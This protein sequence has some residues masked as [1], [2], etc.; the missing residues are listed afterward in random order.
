MASPDTATFA[1]EILQRSCQSFGG[2]AAAALLESRPDTARRFGPDAFAGWKSD[3]AQRVLEL[4]A[5]LRMGE[6]RIFV[7]RV[8]WA[9]K[10]FQA[11]DHDT[12]DLRASLT[13]LR[14]VLKEQL[15]EQGR[16]AALDYLDQ[17]L[18]ALAANTLPTPDKELDPARPNDRI[19][20]SYLQKI[21][22]GDVAGAVDELC[23]AVSRG[24]PVAE[25]YLEV[26]I[27]AQREIG[28]LWH[29]AQVS[30]AEE[31]LVTGAIQ[32]TMAVLAHDTPAAASNGKTVVVAAVT[33]NAH[34]IGL[35][36]AADLY[37]LAGWRAIFLGADVP[38]EDL[39]AILGIFDADVLLLGVSLAPQLPMASQAIKL[40][41]KQCERPVQVI[42]GG[43][44]VDEAPEVWRTL[45]AD[46]YAADLA[47]VERLG[48]RLV[49]LPA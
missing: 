31:H 19:A 49:G 10:A 44:A 40:I 37:Q 11:R 17:G 46:G 26:L 45:G 16:S 29:T 28:R 1:A 15:P 22:S 42:V 4:A 2:Y 32:R 14:D 48:A 8:Q 20:L 21:L 18:A 35:R 33:R 25:A 34:E 3:V 12:G 43:A 5:A 30:V 27:P 36:A 38:Q 47:S 9:R 39:P 41:R 7:A 24:L 13:A 6:P 23:D